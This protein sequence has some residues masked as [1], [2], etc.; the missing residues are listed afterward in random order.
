[1]K[2]LIVFKINTNIGDMVKIG[3]GKSVITNLEQMTLFTPIEK[4]DVFLE[5]SDTEKEKKLK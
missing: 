3:E 2:Y 1:M 4:R 5:Y